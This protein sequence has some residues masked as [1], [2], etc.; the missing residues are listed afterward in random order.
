MLTGKA[1]WH[2]RIHRDYNTV[3]KKTTLT[4]D[5]EICEDATNKIHTAAKSI[6]LKRKAATLSL[7]HPNQHVASSSCSVSTPAAAPERE[8]T[9]TRNTGQ[10]L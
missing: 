10:C 5:I 2:K 3:A 9:N 6:V 8:E 7:P 4:D 1:G